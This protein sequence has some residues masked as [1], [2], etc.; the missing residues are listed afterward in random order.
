MGYLYLHVYRLPTSTEI[1][2]VDRWWSSLTKD[3]QTK[4]VLIRMN[5][6]VFVIIIAT[7]KQNHKILSESDPTKSTSQK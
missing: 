2:T 7:N 5:E 1:D 4:L 6:R 3:W